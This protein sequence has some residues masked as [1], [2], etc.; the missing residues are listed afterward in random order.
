MARGPS[1]LAAKR[2]HRTKTESGLQANSSQA[3]NSEL[4]TRNAGLRVNDSGTPQHLNSDFTLPVTDA[5]RVA[6]TPV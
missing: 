3:R 2:N 5:K 4:G 1:G 6:V